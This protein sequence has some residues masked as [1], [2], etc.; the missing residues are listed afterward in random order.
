MTRDGGH[1]YVGD[2][3]H[4][5]H[6]RTVHGA[7]IEFNYGTES[8]F[9][10]KVDESIGRDVEL[11]VHPQFFREFALQNADRVTHVELKLPRGKGR[12][13][14]NAFRYCAILHLIGDG[15]NH[16]KPIANA[17]VSTRYKWENKEA[18]EN[19]LTT[20]KSKG[21]EIFVIYGIPNARVKDSN[22]ILGKPLE[23]GWVDPEEIA[24]RAEGF[25]YSVKLL[26]NLED[27]NTFNLLCCMA[28]GGLEGKKGLV[29][30]PD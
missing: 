30:D 17:N 3:K 2:V 19:T 26:L 21:D 28:K 16:E 9:Q 4:L 5:A 15:E 12:T 10:A 7:V 18:F 1:I 27:P 29:L 13:E 14:M 11:C 25:G 22:Y 6:Q 20:S 24:V 8:G 23:S